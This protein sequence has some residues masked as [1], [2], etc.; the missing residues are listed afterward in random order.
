M[1]SQTPADKNAYSGTSSNE[2]AQAEPIVQEKQYKQATT[3]FKVSYQS[4]GKPE[5]DI[6]S[7]VMQHTLPECYVPPGL[8]PI[9]LTNVKIEG[10]VVFQA[11]KDEIVNEIEIKTDAQ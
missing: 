8:I 5:S 10:V 9:G 11:Q 3:N 1:V 6:L 7:I 2:T 4:E